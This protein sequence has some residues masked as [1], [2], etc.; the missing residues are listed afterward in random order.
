MSNIR[1]IVD[2]IKNP[3]SNKTLNEE[4]RIVSVKETKDLLE[5]TYNRDGISPEQKRVIEDLFIGELKK[6]VEED[7]IYIKTVSSDSSDVYKSIGSNEPKK[8]EKPASLQ[9]G[10]AK[11]LP[12]KRK[13]DN[14]K[15]VIAVSSGKG[16]VGKSTVSVNLAL[17]LKNEGKKVGLIDADIY[18]PSIP[19]LLGKRDA[20]PMATEGKKI[21]PVEAHG[22]HFISFGLFINEKDPVIWRGPMLGGVLNQFLFDVEWG[23][24][25][26]LIVDLPPGTGDVQLSMIQAVDMTGIIGVSTPQDVAILDSIKGLK[27]FEQVKTPVIG[28]I[29]NMSYFVPDDMPDKKYFIFGE[30]GLK[31]V[32]KE[33]ELSFLG[34]VPLEIELRKSCD[35]GKPYMATTEFNGKP[36]WQAYTSI[37]KK[38]IESTSGEKKGFFSKLLGK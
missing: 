6:A 36:V 37:A 20:K 30:G 13:L 35:S 16:G 21:K 19:M 14:I 38:L 17:S 5:I 26:Y 33:L 28:T 15:N 23:E 7:K 2:T 27:M 24:L 9:V 29:E 10:H 31:Q 3:S 4:G 12:A 34:E 11:G 32:T 18:G 1:A 25:D 8:E 22:I